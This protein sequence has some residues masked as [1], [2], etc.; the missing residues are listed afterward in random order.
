MALTKVKLERL[1]Y[2]LGPLYVKP[3]KDKNFRQMVQE[4]YESSDLVICRKFSNLD[5]IQQYAQ[6]IVL[7]P[8]KPI[9]FKILVGYELVEAYINGETTPINDQLA[10]STLFI[11]ST[12]HAPNKMYGQLIN[13]TIETRKIQGKKTYLLCTVIDSDITYKPITTLV[14]GKEV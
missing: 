9:D 13:Q 2:Y 4:D 12:K 11:F 8:G 3:N 6:R 7:L 5:K 14:D 10:Y 1:K